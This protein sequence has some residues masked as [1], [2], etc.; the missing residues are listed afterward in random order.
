L[1]HQHWQLLHCCTAATAIVNGLPLPPMDRP[2]LF[3][4]VDLQFT[5][6]SGQLCSSIT[7]SVDQYRDWGQAVNLLCCGGCINGSEEQRSAKICHVSTHRKG[8]CTC[9][10]IWSEL[11]YVESDPPRN[12]TSLLVSFWMCPKGGFVQR[13]THCICGVNDGQCLRGRSGVKALMFFVRCKSISSKEVVWCGWCLL[14]FSH[15]LWVGPSFF[16]TDHF[17]LN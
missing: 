5:A 3:C 1:R 9:T 6:K 7:T 12:E 15:Y 2:W 16:Q 11:F 17:Q 4:A 10:Y 8:T 14:L 13:S